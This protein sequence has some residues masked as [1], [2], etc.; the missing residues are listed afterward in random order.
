MRKP[1]ALIV[2]DDDLLADIFSRTLHLVQY[3][4]EVISNG[5]TALEWLQQQ[6]PDLLILDL[7]LPMLSGKQILDNIKGDRRFDRTKI[8]IVTA[9]STM[10]SQLNVDG[11]VILTLVKPVSPIQLQKLAERLKP[12]L[13]R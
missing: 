13:V 11:R 2:E 12:K 9:D 1:F 5:Q 4:T 8:M 3:D 6:V 10:L 7:H